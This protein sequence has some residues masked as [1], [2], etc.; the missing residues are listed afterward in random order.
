M[1][2]PSPSPLFL[3]KIFRNNTS[4]PTNSIKLGV[5]SSTEALNQFLSLLVVARKSTLLLHF[6]SQIPKNSVKINS[7][8]CFLVANSLLKFQQFGHAREVFSLAEKEF[9]FVPNRG[10]L[11]SII[12]CICV[13][14]EDPER[15]FCMLTQCVEEYGIFPSFTTFKTLVSK[16]TSFGN[17]QRAVEVLE[18]MRNDYFGYPIDDFV[19][20]MIISGCCQIGKPELGLRF[21][22][23]IRKV[24]GFSANL[25]SYTAVIYALCQQNKIYEACGIVKA[26]EEKGIVLDEVLY[27]CLVSGFFKKGYLMEG[28]CKYRLMLDS[29]IV[30]DIVNYTNL[31]DGFCKEGYVEKTIGFLISM[32]KNGLKPNLITYSVI[33][34]GFC[35]R[36]KI[37]EAFC[38][39]KR[40]EELGF[41][42]DEFVYATLIDGLCKAR[43]L[44][45]VFNMLGEME[46]K[47]IKVGLV[48]YNT[49]INGLCKEGKT[50][51]GDDLSRD[52]VGDNFTYSTLLH[53]YAKEMNVGGVLETR[54]RLE[55]ANVCVDVIT[56]N[57]LIKA[58]FMV[59]LNEDA[60]MFFKEMR[61][62]GVIANFI[63]YCTMI[64]NL[65]K[66]GMINKALEVFEDYR[67]TIPLSNPFC[68]HCI[69]R[70]LCKENMLDKAIEIF[71]ELAEKKLVSDS[72]IHKKLIIAHFIEGEGN[73]VLKFI[74]AVDSL[75]NE[76]LTK[77]CNDA[78]SYLCRNSS[79]TAALT[80]CVFMRRR[81][82]SIS[83]KSYYVLLKGLIRSNNRSITEL[84]MCD[85]IK[86]EGCF[87]PR[88]TNIITLF[89]CNKNTEEA[90]KYLNGRNKR[91]I[92][93]S[94]L[95]AV[96][97]LLKKESNAHNALIF[98]LEAE[99]HGASMDVV[100][101]SIIIDAF[102]NEGHLEKA[103]DLCS[104]MKEKRI[105]PN[106]VVYNSIIN[107]LCQ[108]GCLT[109]AIRIFN[110]LEQMHINPTVVTYSTLTGALS[111]DGFVEDAELYV[112][113]MLQNGITPNVRIYNSLM[114]GYCSIGMME[115]ALQIFSGLEEN[116]LKPDA[117][118]VSALI[119]GYSQ[120]GD[121]QDAYGFYYE[122][123]KKGL[124][125]DFLGFLGLTEG[126][127]T[128]RR[129]KEALDILKD[130]LQSEKVVDILDRVS[131]EHNVESIANLLSLFCEQGSVH[132]A[133]CVLSEVGSEVF[134]T[135]RSR[136]SSKT[137][138][139]K[140]L[141][142]IG[143]LH[144]ADEEKI[145]E[146]VTLHEMVNVNMK[147]RMHDISNGTE[148]SDCNFD[149]YHSII[150]SLCSKGDLKNANALVKTMI[151]DFAKRS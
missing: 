29:G 82:L 71:K 129:M 137:K 86:V 55:E 115:K 52:F 44:D 68:H 127:V 100:L 73:C 67:R 83:S 66:L 120:K 87:G 150:A 134:T 38:V 13:K 20:S 113:R 107:G 60:C 81:S 30:P 27:S 106:I 26:M 21:Y 114:H 116:G 98:L 40:M 146:N 56:F 145:H 143:S 130:M 119:S 139:L 3:P 77:T 88:M 141:K 64:D 72:S 69:I 6:F 84:L 58:L 41:A 7:K 78:V 110:A 34:H 99:E 105:H 102:C 16:F 147:Y 18:V 93:V 140:Q 80:T 74:H 124:S 62:R 2:I 53:G 79:F 32:E 112:N 148:L 22:E 121:T 36:S 117:F 39:V 92:Y 19:C 75:G 42:L 133:I 15:A 136:D 59:G 14:E 46:S 70:G 89:L 65:C 17:M 28:L 25:V 57:V 4:S 128:K 48:T 125:P 23:K 51:K 104:R 91:D 76:I 43:E 97:K 135:W 5:I 37:A 45:R 138:R 132:E 31:I 10:I 122:C 47:G 61:D 50:S 142:K 90:I 111:R 49:V 85:Y 144:T 63:S 8:T 11:D 109:E 103:L 12:Q 33:L 35:K 126:L 118:T 94:V 54:R 149:N 95:T 151:M 1:I 96:V 108:H 101:Y 9:N 24:N 131:N 123:K